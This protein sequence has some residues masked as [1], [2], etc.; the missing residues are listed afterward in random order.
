LVLTAE[1]AEDAEMR[2]GE[3]THAII[4]AAIEVHKALGPGLLESA[5]EFC[6]AEELAR[7]GIAFER[8]VPLPIVTAGRNS[9]AGIV[10]IFLFKIAWSS[11]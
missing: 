5:Y 4:G 9:T 1:F 11:N 7:R 2:D 6:L 8:Q 3:L 10:W